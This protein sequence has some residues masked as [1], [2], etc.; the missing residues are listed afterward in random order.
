MSLF[1]VKKGWDQ[2]LLV[3]P[4]ILTVFVYFDDL[5]KLF[6]VHSLKSCILQYVYSMKIDTTVNTLITLHEA[7]CIYNQIS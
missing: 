2:P 6:K 1:V 7:L 5:W 4:L 3:A